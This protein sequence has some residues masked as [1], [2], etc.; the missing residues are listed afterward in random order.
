[1][2]WHTTQLTKK[3]QP[4]I[5]ELTRPK[6]TYTE[7]LGERLPIPAAVFLRDA[8][9]EMRAEGADHATAKSLLLATVAA[10]TTGISG[11]EWH[12][13][14]QTPYSLAEQNLPPNPT[15]AQR[16]KAL[17]QAYGQFRQIQSNNKP[18]KELFGLGP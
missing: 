4:Y 8:Y 17:R 16:N 7:F 2:P 3:G 15:D 12:P 5:S 10:A 14:R 9:D 1:M 18:P 13:D 11:Y 6:L